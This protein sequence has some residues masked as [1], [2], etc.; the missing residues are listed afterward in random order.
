L[1]QEFNITII[2]KPGKK[3][4]VVNFLSR[5][6]INSDV[7]PVNDNFPDEHLFFVSTHTFWFADITNYLA[8]RKLQNNLPSDKKWKII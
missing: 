5:I 8:T 2:D 6:N 4:V 3:Y 1:L 7:I